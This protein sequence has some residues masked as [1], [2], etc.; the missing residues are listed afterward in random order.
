M[1]KPKRTK[2]NFEFEQTYDAAKLRDY[3]A[4]QNKAG[5]DAFRCNK[6]PGNPCR[7]RLGHKD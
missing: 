5:W 2:R 4:G 3:K 6:F 1:N 7:W